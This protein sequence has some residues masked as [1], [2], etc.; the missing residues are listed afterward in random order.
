MRNLS[1]FYFD[2]TTNLNWKEIP[3]RSER[4]FFSKF[5]KHTKRRRE[6]KTSMDYTMK[7]D[8]H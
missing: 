5:L 4:F 6:N 2:T 7:V 3:K 8:G 1:G